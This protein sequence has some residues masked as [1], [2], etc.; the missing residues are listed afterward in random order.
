MLAP[1]ADADY[2]GKYFIPLSPF[3]QG[4]QQE[5]AGPGSYEKGLSRAE[6]SIFFAKALAGRRREK[7]SEA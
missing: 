2:H 4:I 5:H 1:W 7:K 6:I 3:R